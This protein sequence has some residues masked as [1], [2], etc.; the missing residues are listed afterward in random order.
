M[1][2]IIIEDSRLAR[3]GLA[4]ML[5][6]YPA[7]ELVGMAESAQAALQLIQ[8]QQPELLFLDIHMPGEDGFSVL[9]QIDYQPKVIFTTAH[10]EYA[11]RS[12][13]FDTVDYLVKPISQTRLAQSI[14]KLTHYHEAA[15]NSRNDKKPLEPNSKIFL[16]DGTRCHLISISEIDYIESCKNYVQLFFNGQHAYLKKS[17]NSV[18]ERLPTG[19]FFRAN[20]Q[21]LINLQSVRAI[22]ESMQQGY[23]V[24]LNTGAKL[25]ISRRNAQALKDVLSI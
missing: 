4:K 15:S 19:M 14:Q 5:A 25:E 24:T 11:I 1:K 22:E 12:F 3:E 18:E 23:I 2:A 10:T 9:E 20:R 16:K 17:M 21:H 8:E 6:Q 13:D 7:V